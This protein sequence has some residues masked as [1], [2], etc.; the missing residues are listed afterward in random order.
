MAAAKFPLLTSDV[1]ADIQ[2]CW[3]SGACISAKEHHMHKRHTKWPIM[4][5]FMIAFSIT[6]IIPAHLGQITNG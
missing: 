3:T 1:K 6:C 2:S 4:V 5:K